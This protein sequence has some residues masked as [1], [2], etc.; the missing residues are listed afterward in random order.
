MM[1]GCSVHSSRRGV[2]RV[3]L[4]RKVSGQRAAAL[5]PPLHRSGLTEP[6]T[7]YP[8][9]CRRRAACRA[10]SLCVLCS[11]SAR[12]SEG[13]LSRAPRRGRHNDLMVGRAGIL[14]EEKLGKQAKGG[15]K[16]K[17]GRKRKEVIETRV[18]D[19]DALLGAPFEYITSTP[20]A[21]AHPRLSIQ[22]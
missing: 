9:P 16:G 3:Y 14:I 11:F 17:D 15:G 12:V 7:R 8:G 1:G 21:I 20:A 6:E 13:R 22:G 5:S 10:P 2:L 4:A 19:P 18:A